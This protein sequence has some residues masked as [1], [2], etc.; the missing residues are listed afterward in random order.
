MSSKISN[1]AVGVMVHFLGGLTVATSMSVHGIARSVGFGDEMLLTDAIIDANRDRHGRCPLL[2]LLDDDK[3]QINAWSS[4]KV[5]RGPWPADVDRILPG[6]HAWD[7]ARDR[8]RA[9]A[10][11]LPS[12]DEQRAALVLVR[13]KYGVPTSAQSRTL[14]E[15]GRHR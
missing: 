4:I 10:V 13:E 12:E 2:E 14:A 3:G 9:E 6:S 1:S 15:Y 11:A 8:A 5:R 7:L